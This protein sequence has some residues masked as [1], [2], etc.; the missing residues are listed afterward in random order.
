MRVW[1]HVRTLDTG[2]AQDLI[3]WSAFKSSRVGFLTV[4]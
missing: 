1:G 2:S 4:I 3:P